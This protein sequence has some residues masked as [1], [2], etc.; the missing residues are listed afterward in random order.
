[1][2]IK[3]L[4]LYL[5]LISCNNKKQDKPK[6]DN[7]VIVS[8]P[9]EMNILQKDILGFKEYWEELGIAI[10]N[11]DTNKLKLLVADSLKIEGHEDEDPH[12]IVSSDQAVKYVV[13]AIKEGEYY[14]LEKNTFISYKTMFQSDLK[15]IREY[16]EGGE[17]QWIED[18]VFEKTAHGWKLISLYMDTKDSG[19][20]LK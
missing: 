4:L 20:K 19:R 18:F 5:V 14:D 9:V 10:Q 2:K 1:M 13:L 6:E 12:F 7:S 16:K 3:L 8:K 17:S 11:E 15:H